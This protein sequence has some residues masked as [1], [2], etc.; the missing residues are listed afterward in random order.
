MSMEMI[1]MACQHCYA[2]IGTDEFICQHCKVIGNPD[3][4]CESCLETVHEYH[5][6][7]GFVPDCDACYWEMN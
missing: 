6:D 4:V 7:E 2:E 5:E 1:K 3:I